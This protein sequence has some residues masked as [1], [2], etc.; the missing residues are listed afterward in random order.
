MSIVLSKA[1]IK[2]NEKLMERSGSFKNPFE[3]KT[4][5]AKLRRVPIYLL[6]VL[7]I[8]PYYWMITSSLKSVKELQVVPPTLFDHHHHLMMNFE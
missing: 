4:R 5:A 7:M 2:R 8:A 3:H 6:T 1:D